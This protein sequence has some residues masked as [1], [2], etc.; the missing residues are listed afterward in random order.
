VAN[1]QYQNQKKSLNYSKKHIDRSATSIRKKICG[2]ERDLAIEVIQNFREYHLYPLMLVK[3]HLQRTANII[4]PKI[5]I[6]RR[7]KRL[8]TI[9]NK[10][11]RPTLDGEESNRIKI[12]RMQDIAGCR[13]IVNNLDELNSLQKKLLNS[14]S[15]HKIIRVRNYLTPKESGYGGIHLI[16]SCFEDH[17]G[18]HD[19][20]KTNVEVQLRT[21]LQHAWATTLEIIDTL[22]N[23]QLKTSHNGHDDWRRF[24]Y[25]SGC[26]VAHHEKACIYSEQDIWAFKEELVA[27]FCK[28]DFNLKLAKN[29]FAIK[30][31]NTSI[32][33]PSKKYNNG[34]CLISLIEKTNKTN[35]YDV[36]VELFTTKDS[37]YAIKKYNNYELDNSI[38][39][40]A[41]VSVQDAKNLKKAYPNYFGSTALFRQFLSQNFYQMISQY[42]KEINSYRSKTLNSDE[43]LDILNNK[44]DILIDAINKLGL[45]DYT[46]VSI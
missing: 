28:L 45:K 20:K 36:K 19:W 44:V 22:E 2:P 18:D 10:L 30:F 23:I 38:N 14:R 9:I 31:A 32:N 5:I 35:S 4:N 17:E 16:Y 43:E 13:A 33:K 6:A 27:L 11:E 12:T 3:N 39:F 41:L 46:S 7:L 21:Q 26:L 1:H 24:F 15:V 34:M 29:T 40:C 37:A 25:L 8:P 42:K